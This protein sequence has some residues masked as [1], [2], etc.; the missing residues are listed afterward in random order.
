MKKVKINLIH[1]DERLTIE[2]SVSAD[3]YNRL[4]WAKEGMD[5][6]D[7]GWAIESIEE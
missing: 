1:M 7:E 5:E 6:Y 4:M 2:V 3:N